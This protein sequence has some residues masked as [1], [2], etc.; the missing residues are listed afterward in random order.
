MKKF[1]FNEF[2]WLLTLIAMEVILI[3]LFKSKEI[4]NYLEE[5]ILSLRIV[6]AIFLIFI[7]VQ[8][9][10]VFTFNSRQDESLKALPIILSILI[11]FL[12]VSK[13]LLLG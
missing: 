6:Q 7:A 3:Y 2:I 5:G 13:R 1:N 9:P 8:I 4:Y 10:K 12:F 11:I